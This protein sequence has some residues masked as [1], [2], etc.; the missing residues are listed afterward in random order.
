[1][2]TY[3]DRY[4]QFKKDGGYKILPF[5]KLPEKNTDIFLTYNSTKRL[6]IISD[7]YYNNPYYGWLILSANPSFGGL[8]FN[9][10]DG[11]TIRIPYPLNVS[12]SQYEE[13]LVRYDNL[14]GI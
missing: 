1:M 10:P 5:I 7:E 4:R 12:L 3:Y 14:F 6:D 8:E 2:A 9:I 11:T 13:A